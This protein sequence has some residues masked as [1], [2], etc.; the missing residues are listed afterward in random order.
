[1][2]TLCRLAIL[3]AR[4]FALLLTLAVTLAG[5]NFA[6]PAGSAAVQAAP[7]DPNTL[8]MAE[9]Y[10]PGAIDWQ[11][12][13]E[14]AELDCGTLTLP[15]DYQQPRGKTFDMAVIRARTLNSSKYIGVLFTHPGIHL[16]GVDFILSGVDTPV[17]NRIRARFD[18]VS[19]DPR[20]AGRTRKLDC[21]F[22]LPDVPTDQSDASLIAYFDDYG[23]RVAEQCLDQDPGFVLSISANS[24]A[25]DIEMF[26]RALGEHRL[27]FGMISNSGPVAAVY[28]SLFPKR[29]RAMLID[30][31]VA[32][33]F[34]DYLIERWSEESASYDLALRRADQICRRDVS[35]PLH[36]MGVVAAFDTVFARL[37]TEP[38]TAPNG[39]KFTARDL[40]DTFFNLLPVEQR[41]PLVAGALSQALAGDFTLFFQLQSPPSNAGDGFI[42]RSCNDYGTRRTAADYLPMIE[43]VGDTY[44]RFIGRFMLANIIASCSAWPDADP[45]IIH[46]VQRQLDV[47]ILLIGSEFDP[48]VPL[49]WTKRMAQA[50]GMEQHV[51]RYQGGGH[52]LVQR[53]DIPCISD[54]IDSYLFDLRLPSEGYTCPAVSLAPRV[55]QNGTQALDAA[56]DEPWG[57]EQLDIRY[58]E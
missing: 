48:A 36:E 28:A 29:V 38:V 52:V 31:T 17:F 40:S 1:M 30:S 57:M 39:T 23:R 35:C 24:F 20:G 3:S 56:N 41:W 13:P 16:A 2:R 22:D 51:V 11:P 45:P 25:R 46:N 55:Q 5:L 12:C 43:A 42:A 32:P 7:D 26:R 9:G 33:E 58:G 37:L 18:I 44:P 14:N 53:S 21:G 50:L 49:S 8:D 47:P 54:V 27:S 15:V 4:P 6:A 10:T 19:L 34:R